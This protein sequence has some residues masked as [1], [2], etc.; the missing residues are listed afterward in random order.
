[1]SKLGKYSFEDI[2]QLTKE[3]L[4]KSNLPMQNEFV[5]ASKKIEYTKGDNEACEVV[6]NLFYCGGQIFF[7][8]SAK[9]KYGVDAVRNAH[10]YFK[11]LIQS[12]SVNHEDKITICGWIAS[13]IF[14]LE[15]MGKPKSD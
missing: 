15:K 10:K 2:P 12:F 8:E 11:S 6:S 14:D 3:D 7:S 4:F 9:E 1:M 13:C 5:E